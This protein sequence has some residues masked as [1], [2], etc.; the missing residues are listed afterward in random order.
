MIKSHDEDP[1]KFFKGSKH[2]RSKGVSIVFKPTFTFIQMNN[3]NNG[4]NGN[5]NI[6]SGNIQGDNEIHLVGDGYNVT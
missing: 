2:K 3:S 1:I 5:V 4:N 6:G